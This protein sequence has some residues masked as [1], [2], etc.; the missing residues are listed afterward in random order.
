MELFEILKA[1][2]YIAGITLLG[3][4]AFLLF[5]FILITKDIRRMTAR[6][7]LLT[8]INGWWQ[9]LKKIPRSRKKT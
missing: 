9:L 8:D 2:V 7:E 5:Q 1:C 3:L 6:I 4:L